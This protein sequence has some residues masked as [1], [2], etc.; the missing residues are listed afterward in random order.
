MGILLINGSPRKNGNTHLLAK[1]IFSNLEGAEL[2]NVCEYNIKGCLGC[3]ACRNNGN[4]CV[5]KDD[6][7]YLTDK[8]KENDTIIFL[9]PMYWWGITSQLK[10][11]IDRMYV[12]DYLKNKKKK[13]I[14]IISIGAD[15]LEDKEYEI[16]KIQFESMCHYFDWNF[17]LNHSFCARKKGEVLENDIKI[18][19]IID[20]IKK[21]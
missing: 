10:S 12:D 5:I 19:K 20:E 6:G 18:K 7:K 21:I 14:G 16:V 11:L 9:S 4:I 1:E 17:S 15:D 13:N 3:E 8:I 2:I